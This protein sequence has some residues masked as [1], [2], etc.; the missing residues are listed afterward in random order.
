[1]LIKNEK[2]EQ[3][4]S[5]KYENS[6]KVEQKNGPADLENEKLEKF[7]L[8]EKKFLGKF[9]YE[10]FF[11]YPTPTHCYWSSSGLAVG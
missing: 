10:S 7:F 2:I 5:Y 1:M 9:W 6:S 4:C 11:P 3:N 8:C